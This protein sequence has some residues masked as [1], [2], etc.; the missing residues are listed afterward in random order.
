[1]S[2]VF[3]LQRKRMSNNEFFIL[4]TICKISHKWSTMLVIWSLVPSPCHLWQMKQNR[5]TEECS[6]PQ[7]SVDIT[8]QG[9][10][11][12]NRWTHSLS[13]L[14][15]CVVKADPSTY[16]P[17]PY[18]LNIKYISLPPLLWMNVLLDFNCTGFEERK[19]SKNICIRSESNQRLLAF[20][21]ATQTTR[22]LWQL[23]TCCEFF[24]T[25]FLR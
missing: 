3:W 24:C 22:L 20:H 14:T 11:F 21:H 19:V 6:K 15:T 18:C 5:S 2:L 17:P 1:M 25:T 23:T 9:K 16:K 4:N 8:K 13:D 12:I 7:R 10:P